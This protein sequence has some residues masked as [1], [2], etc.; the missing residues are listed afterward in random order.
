MAYRTTN[1]KRSTT[2]SNTKRSTTRRSTSPVRMSAAKRASEAA[3][4]RGVASGMRMRRS[5]SRRS[6]IYS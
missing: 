4:K 2:R 5:G 1:Q 3:F 6:Y